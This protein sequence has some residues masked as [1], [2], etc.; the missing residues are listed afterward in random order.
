MTHTVT[1]KA[2]SSKAKNRLANLM[3]GDPVCVVEQNSNG[4]LFLAS[5][6]GKNY[7]WIS[8]KDSDWIIV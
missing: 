7:F 4:R 1:V 3:G 5:S 8:P 2:I 6:N